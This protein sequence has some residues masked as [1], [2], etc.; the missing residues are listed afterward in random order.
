MCAEKEASDHLAAAMRMIWVSDRKAR[1]G[2]S[3]AQWCCGGGGMRKS[4]RKRA[5]DGPLRPAIILIACLVNS[6]IVW[7]YLSPFTKDLMTCMER[8]LISKETI[9]CGLATL[10]P[11]T[12]HLLGHQ[13]LH[14]DWAPLDC[15][16]S[17]LLDKQP[18]LELEGRL[19]L[20]EV[21]TRLPC[22]VVNRQPEPLHKEFPRTNMTAGTLHTRRCEDQ[23]AIPF[24]RQRR[25]Q[26]PRIPMEWLE[27]A[28]VENI[29]ETCTLREQQA[30]GHVP[31]ALQ[32]L[33]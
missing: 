7:E 25:Q 18:V 16:I 31:N 6:P 2:N 8:N 21:L 5:V 23:T 19:A 29:V 10:A 11:P 3:V 33:K 24:G 12:D 30:I 32:I 13:T 26:C 14:L 15:N 27:N 1:F 28:D 4:E 22:G 9:Y 20:G 17:P